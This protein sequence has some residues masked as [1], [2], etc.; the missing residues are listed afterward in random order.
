MSGDVSPFE[1]IVREVDRVLR[2]A[3]YVRV[4]ELRIG[5]VPFEVDY[6][7]LAG[8]GFLDLVLVI[9]AD[10]PSSQIYWLAERVASA[11]D[12]VGSRRPITYV[13]VGDARDEGMVTDELIKLGRVVHVSGPEH[14]SEELAPLLPVVLEQGHDV[15]VDP[16]AQL[17]L[18]A[19][20]QKGDVPAL[21]DFVK[22][23][24]SGANSVEANLASWFDAAFSEVATSND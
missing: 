16:L 15:E 9:D 17:D 11:L 13:L 4:N 24:R 1:D 3:Q 5:D 10:T 6:S 19:G 20:T 22:A 21:S 12:G 7:Y 18:S 2:D 8:P 14:V 23:A